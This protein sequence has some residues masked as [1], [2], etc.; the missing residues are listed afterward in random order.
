MYEAMAAGPAA[1]L[2]RVHR[3]RGA[4]DAPHDQGSRARL[5]QSLLRSHAA[6]MGNVVDTEITRGLMFL[7][8]R[9]LATGRT[10]VRPAVAEAL[11]ALLNAGIT[12]V[13][14]EHG[15]LGC[16]GDLAPLAHCALAL[17]GE[18]EV[19][20][21]DGEPTPTGPCSKPPASSRSPWRPRKASPSS[22]GP[23]ACSPCS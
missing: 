16:S 4:G 12:P 21:D 1:R 5:Q 6:G 3:L 20:G 14:R 10:G 11:A 13:V 7:R 22:M 17:I 8:L 9:T 15:S 18:G 23:T 19:L 2:R